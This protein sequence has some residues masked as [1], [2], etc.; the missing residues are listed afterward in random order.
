MPPLQPEELVTWILESLG[1][2]VRKVPHGSTR[3]PDFIVTIEGVRYL[4]ELKAKEEDPVR[5]GK[6]S[7]TLKQGKAAEDHDTVGRKNVIAGLV[8]DAAAQLRAFSAEAV[9]YRLVWLLGW[10]R[11]RKLYVEQCESALYGTTSIVDLDAGGDGYARDAYYFGHSD[12]FRHR[13]I[14]DGAITWCDQHGKFLVNDLGSR[15]AQFRTSPLAETMA[16]GRI[17]PREQERQGKAYYVGS[18]VDRRN[19]AAVLEFLQKKYGRPRLM[20][21]Q[22]G[23]HAAAMV[24]PG[25]STL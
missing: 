21:I 2:Q 24:I 1:A 18:D 5:E 16:K 22:L 20:N 19:E 14:L 11:L 3:T 12:F 25:G 15:Y 9:D 8:A 6:R 10:G 4:I 7:E 23:Y 13:D 17:D